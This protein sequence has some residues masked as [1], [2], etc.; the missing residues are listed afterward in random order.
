M[1]AYKGAA[2]TLTGSVVITQSRSGSVPKKKQKTPI[3]KITK[4]NVNEIF[5]DVDFEKVLKKYSLFKYTDENGL[6]E[7]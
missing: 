7:V 4:D 1:S 3:I 2:R 5:P 6:L